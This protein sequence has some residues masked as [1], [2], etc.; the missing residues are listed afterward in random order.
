MKEV[1]LGVFLDQ[2]CR[3]EEKKKDQG[4]GHVKPCCGLNKGFSR[5]YM[6]L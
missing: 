3:R 6:T 5:P 2:Q 4:E 1:Y